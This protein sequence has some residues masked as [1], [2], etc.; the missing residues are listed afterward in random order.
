MKAKW[1]IMSSRKK[2]RQLFECVKREYLVD[3]LKRMKCKVQ[4]GSAVEGGGRKAEKCMSFRRML[5]LFRVG[6][7]YSSHTLARSAPSFICARVF[8]SDENNSRKSLPAQSAAEVC[9]AHEKYINVYMYAFVL[10]IES[11]HPPENVNKETN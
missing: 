10:S 1:K 3:S 6:N 11:P 8:V 5:L 9:N 4:R 7:A 2:I